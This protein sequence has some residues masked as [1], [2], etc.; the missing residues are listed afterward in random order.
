MLTLQQQPY[1]LYE[2][3]SYFERAYFN[4]P[5][6]AAWKKYDP[7]RKKLEESYKVLQPMLSKIITDHQKFFEYTTFGAS[8]GDTWVG[9]IVFSIV[10]LNKSENQQR[11][12]ALEMMELL[13]AS[14]IQEEA[15]DLR[16][17]FIT[18]LQED[19]MDSKHKWELLYIYENFD[20]FASEITTIIETLRPEVR[21]QLQ[22]YQ[23]EVS[24]FIDDITQNTRQMSL[25]SYIK[26]VVRVTIENAKVRV[27]YPTVFGSNSLTIQEQYVFIGILFDSSFDFQGENE[28]L[29]LLLA[30]M[31]VLTDPS[32]FAI[33][34]ELH[35]ESTYGNDLAKEMN[36]TPATISHHM[37]ALLSEGLVNLRTGKSKRIYYSVNEE[38]V[39]SILQN[40]EEQ[41]LS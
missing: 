2:T 23:V 21:K 25:E 29:D 35:K 31:K 19:E 12:F 8:E 18:F 37:N 32:K 15:D 22:M 14:S 26:K 17:T 4:K 3:F 30:K 13:K 38:A 39:K 33:L 20:F 24:N 9:F 1:E 7:L 11:A 28:E 40:V 10:Y 6:T 27:M 5:I 16:S 41:L 34:K 36:L